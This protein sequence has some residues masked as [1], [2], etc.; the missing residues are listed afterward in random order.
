MMNLPFGLL[1]DQARRAWR[2]RVRPGGAVCIGGADCGV[3]SM[4]TRRG[5]P[6]WKAL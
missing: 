4:G 5:A 1:L 3:Q 6:H 2:S